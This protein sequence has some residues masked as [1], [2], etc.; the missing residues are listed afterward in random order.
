MY[1]YTCDHTSLDIC[2]FAC[3]A[4][5]VSWIEYSNPIVVGV[6]VLSSWIFPVVKLS[7]TSLLHF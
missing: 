5:V 2:T 4:P 6:L 3:H 1:I 7:F